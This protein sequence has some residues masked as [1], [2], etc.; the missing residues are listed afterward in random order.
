M[1]PATKQ[2]IKLALRRY[3]LRWLRKLVDAID[4]RLHTAE[5]TL[6]NDLQSPQKEEHHEPRHEDRN[7]A[8]PSQ[9]QDEKWRGSFLSSGADDGREGIPERSLGYSYDFQGVEESEQQTAGSESVAPRHAQR[10]SADRHHESWTEWEARRSGIA[11]ISKK[12]ARRRRE[13][14]SARAFD[15]KVAR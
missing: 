14:L 13:R 3:T 12:A 9:I 1:N 10:L 6:R 8:Y 5:V 7:K 11:P 15:L 2:R 4:D